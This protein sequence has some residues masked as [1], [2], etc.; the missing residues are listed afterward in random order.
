MGI[1]SHAEPIEYSDNRQPDW[2]YHELLDHILTNGRLSSSGMDEEM[3]KITGYPMRFDLHNGF[4]MITERD[5]MASNFQAASEHAADLSHHN[6]RMSARQGLGEII[7]FINGARTL[8]ELE[9]YG[10]K[11]WA[12]WVSPAKTAKRGLEPGDLGPGSY[13]VAFHDFPMANGKTFNQIQAVYEQIKFRPELLTHYVTPYIPYETI[14]LEGRQQ[15]VVVVPCHG[16]I[17]FE[18]DTNTGEM[19]LSHVQRSADVPVGLPFNMIHYAALLTMMAQV[20][21]YKPRELIYYVDSGQIYKRHYE[22]TQRI[23]GRDPKPFA[24]LY[25]DPSVTNIFD[26]RVEHFSVSEYDAHP[27]IDMG[28]TPV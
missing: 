5:L 6:F 23:L 10:C 14:R 19:D 11:Y 20:T 13:G 28:G 21:G 24:K 2:Q 25:V 16:L 27:N 15:G 8:E 17:R 18:V 22:I 7:G 26:F 3:L 4:P 1:E 9:M 12:P